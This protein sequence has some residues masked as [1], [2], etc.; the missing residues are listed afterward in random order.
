MRQA[1]CIVGGGDLACEVRRRESIF[2]GG[3]DAKG[4]EGRLD[5]RMKMM[6]GR[7]DVRRET[8]GVEVSVKEKG[9]PSEESWSEAIEGVG[10]GVRGREVGGSKGGGEVGGSRGGGEGGT[11]AMDD[12][13]VRRFR[14]GAEVKYLCS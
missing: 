12:T 8:Q 10:G 4:E 14:A 13:V 3:S 11:E 5:E 1:N 2:V 9:Q 6:G 7:A